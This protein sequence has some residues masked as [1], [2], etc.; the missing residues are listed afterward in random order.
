MSLGVSIM[1]T[2]AAARLRVPAAF[3]RN[4]FFCDRLMA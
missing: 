2:S 1:D 4:A 3:P